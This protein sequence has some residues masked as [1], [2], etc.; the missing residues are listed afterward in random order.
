[1]Y[2]CRYI[3]DMC[4]MTKGYDIGATSAV[5]SQLKTKTYSGV[6]WYHLVS[7]SSVL[8]VTQR[9]PMEQRLIGRGLEKY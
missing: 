2:A 6:D 7:A 1:M 3:V 4:C 5:L 9:M 8:Q